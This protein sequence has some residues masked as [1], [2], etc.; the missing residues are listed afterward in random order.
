[1]AALRAVL[2]KLSPTERAAYLLREAFD[3]RYRELGAMLE[4]S[5]PSARQV[6]NRARRRLSDAPRR[7]VGVAEHERLVAAVRS[8]LM[9]RRR[10]A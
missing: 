1:M 9:S 6:V 2:E 5:E 7:S 4:L 8:L 3:Y 10:A